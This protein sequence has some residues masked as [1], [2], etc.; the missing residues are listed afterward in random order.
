MQWESLYESSGASQVFPSGRPLWSWLEGALQK[1]MFSH[2]CLAWGGIWWELPN[3]LPLVA[4]YAKIGSAWEGLCC[5][6]RL[7]LD[8]GPLVGTMMWVEASYH[9]VSPVAASLSYITG[10]L[11]L[12]PTLAKSTG[13]TE[14]SCCTPVFC[15]P[16]WD[17]RRIRSE[18]WERSLLQAPTGQHV[19]WGEQYYQVNGELRLEERSANNGACP[20]FLPQTELPL[21]PSLLPS[22]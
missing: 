14:A 12:M 19:G 21:P 7:A 18:S 20:H 9:C 15:V 17:F 13:H 6:S 22:S 4:T 5:D 8:W 10:W 11:Q 1:A 16:L 3:D 2:L